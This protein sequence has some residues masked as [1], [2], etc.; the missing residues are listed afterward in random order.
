MDAVTPEGGALVSIVL[1]VVAFWSLAAVSVLRD[2]APRLPERAL[3]LF[4]A[5]GLAGTLLGRNLSYLSIERIGPS[6]QVTIRLSQTIVTLLFGLVF[7]GEFPRPW[8]LAGL[9]SVV[10]GLWISLRSAGPADWTSQPGRAPQGSRRLDVSAVAIA[11]ASVAAF[12]LGDTA[13]RAALM[14]VPAP[15]LGAAIG[16]SAALAAHLA[17][18]I[19]RHSARWPRGASLMRVDVWASAAFNTLALL[20]LYTALRASPVAI[21]STLYNLQVLVVLV[22]SRWLL[23]DREP[24]GPRLAGG[25]VLALAGTTLILLG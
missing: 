8:Q 23:R 1:N 15:L 24:I 9:A 4:V 14:I 16:A 7:L 22:G 17:W 6:L 12:S 5:G 11:F 20:F 2:G 25:A 3:I 19:T 13:R 10:A 21:V 18:S